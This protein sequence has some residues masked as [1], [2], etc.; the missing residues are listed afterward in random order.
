Y[1][2]AY[3]PNMN[4][5]NSEE[6]FN[7][8][9]RECL[10]CQYKKNTDAYPVSKEIIIAYMKSLEVPEGIFKK[11][12]TKKIKEF[13]LKMKLLDA[14]GDDSFAEISEKLYGYPDKDLV[15]KAY[16]LLYLPLSPVETSIDIKDAKKIMQNQLSALHIDW[17]VY[18][19]KML[20]RA[21]IYPEKKEVR[22]NSTVSFSENTI[23]RLAVH[24]IGT[25]AVRA[26]N[27]RTQPLRIFKNFPSYIV[28]EEGLAVFNEHITGL[29]DNDSIRKY[30][31]RVVAV[32]YAKTHTFYETFD[33]LCTFFD[34]DTAFYITLRVKRGLKDT[35]S[36][37]A[38]TKDFVYLKGY[39]DVKHFAQKNPLKILY[40]GKVPLEYVSLVK[41]IEPELS[42]IAYF[43]P[44]VES[45]EI[46]KDA[47]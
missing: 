40:Y 27:A 14:I 8:T 18:A 37:G 22:L 7:N 39:F 31:G 25:H 32:D 36:L 38:Y 44:L 2:G 43:P 34:K 35:N 13:I 23:K 17:K 46:K 3:A 29:L 6:I 15:K 12:Y 20:A 4:P 26:M 16:S 1:A 9:K 19:R 30:A 42:K 5:I 45:F 10:A 11:V 21:S 28:T 41:K 24:E 33:Y 47:F